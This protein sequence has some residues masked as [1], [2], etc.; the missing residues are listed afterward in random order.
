EA[1]CAPG[2]RR[3]RAAAARRAYGWPAARARRGDA[4]DGDL[5]PRRRPRRPARR[6]ARRRRAR[7]RHPRRPRAVSARAA[8]GPV[9]PNF[10]HASRCVTDNR[11]F[12]T[13]WVRAHW[14]DTLEPALVQHVRLSAI[15]VGIGFALALVLALVSYRFR[16]LD[17][18]IGLVSDFL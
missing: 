9:I 11:L 15:A 14:H 4:A 17:H 13:D 2:R 3:A 18:P 5:D 7:R 8:G 10:G 1:A 12:C 16:T 6:H